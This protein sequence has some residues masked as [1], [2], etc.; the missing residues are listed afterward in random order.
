MTSTPAEVTRLQSYLRENARKQYD[1]QALPPFTIFI[2]VTDPCT[3]FN[4]AIPD[5]PVSGDLAV[6]LDDLRA[7]FHARAR[8]AR[9]EFFEAFAPE[10]PA[11]LRKYG[12]E[13]EARQW[14]MTCTP[15]SLR[16]PPEVPG[17]SV[18]AIGAGSSD[19][20]L[21]DFMTA[22]RQG[23]DPQNTSPVTEEA[24]ALTRKSFARSGAG[25]FLGRID[26]AAAGA[27]YFGCPMDGV[28]ELA[29]IATLEA[30]RRR[31]IASLLTWYTAR[32]VFDAGVEVAFL[33]A[34]DARA[35][36]V[37]ERVGFQPFSIMLAY[38]DPHD[39]GS[40]L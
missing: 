39:E 8:V 9:F 21:R 34:E 33:T 27:S 15:A 1:S 28:S 13:E 7:A 16:R 23:F 24:I 29:G 5:G 3:Y 30:F 20:D 18:T 26:G 40:P 10:L 6:L 35:G 25:G 36:R 17:L 2:K 14:S 22:Q 32:A 38:C 19:E 31:G 11:A 37:Y 4:Y 12:F